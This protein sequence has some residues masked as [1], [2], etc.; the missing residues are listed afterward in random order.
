MTSTYKVQMVYYTEIYYNPDDKV[1][2]SIPRFKSPISIRYLDT[3][4]TSAV[5]VHLDEENKK[6]F[7][8]PLLLKTSINVFPEVLTIYGKKYMTT[9]S[10]EQMKNRL[11]KE[12]LINKKIFF[13]PDDL[14]E[15]VISL[16]EGVPLE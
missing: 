9:F 7:A 10:S 13:K 14:K 3:D 12:F 4:E 15:K 6:L 5:I 16:L 8:M 1:P 11:M 2:H